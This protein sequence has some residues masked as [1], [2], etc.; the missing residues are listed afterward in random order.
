[1]RED[2]QCPRQIGQAKPAGADGPATAWAAGPPRPHRTSR[3]RLSEWLVNSGAYMHWIS[4][5]PV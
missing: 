5:M 3:A 2:V 1:M 4:A